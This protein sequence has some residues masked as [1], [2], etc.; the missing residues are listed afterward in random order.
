MDRS[1]LSQTP[2]IEASRRFVCVRLSTYENEQEG[3]FLKS[4]FATGSGELENSVFVVLAPDGKRTLV[5]AHRSVRHRFADADELAERMNRLSS[6]FAERRPGSGPSLPLV[7]NLRL[8]LNVAACDNRPL[9]V[10]RAPNGEVPQRLATTLA[11]LAWSDRYIGQ[12]LY[13]PTGSEKELAAVH[14]VEPSGSVLVIQPDRYG[15][16]GKVLGQAP[17]QASREQITRL[18]RDAAAAFQPEPKTFSEHVREGRKQGVFW[19]TVIPVTDPME[20][21]ARER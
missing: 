6:T 17:A 15:R 7:A 9:V 2:V 20:R 21:R 8:A 5:G 14:G 11:E 12:F 13:A 10:V 16:E 19:E 1:F 18:L 3:K 4:L